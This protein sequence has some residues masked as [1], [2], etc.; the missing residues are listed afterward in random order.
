M[1]NCGHGLDPH[2][3]LDSHDANWDGHD[4][5]LIC[6]ISTR[7]DRHDDRDDVPVG[8]ANGI[9]VD[10]FGLRSIEDPRSRRRYCIIPLRLPLRVD[11]VRCCCLHRV[12][13]YGQ[14]CK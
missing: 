10:S 6:F 1:P 2:G 4:G 13:R 11:G 9:V 12:G 3:Y 5:D 7:L 8:G 14:A